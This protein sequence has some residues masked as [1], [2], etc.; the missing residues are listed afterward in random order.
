MIDIWSDWRVCLDRVRVGYW[1]I[2]HHLQIF[3]LLECSGGKPSLMDDWS[4]Q[5]GPRMFKCS[6]DNE[7]IEGG[8]K[9]AQGDAEGTRREWLL[10]QHSEFQFYQM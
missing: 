6:A 7:V 5:Q 10:V 3:E 2:A 8:K 9:N 4:L 1:P